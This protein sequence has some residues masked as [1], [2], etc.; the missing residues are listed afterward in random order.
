MEAYRSIFKK[1]WAPLTAG[2]L[3]GFI[4]TLMFAFDS[5]W[6]VF[7]GLRNWGLHIL[8]FLGAGDVAQRS[9]LEY[10]T[11][12]MDIA[13]ITGAF[14]AAL[15]AN[16]FGVRIPPLREAIK[17][18]IGGVLMGIG[19]NFARGCT[20]GG[21][22]SSIAAMSVSGLCMMLGLFIGVII[23]LKYLLWENR[24]AA[25]TGFKAGRSFG[26]PS[27]IQIPLG[28]L[29]L[30]AGLVGVPYYYDYLDYNELGV[31]FAFSAALGVISQRSRFCI[32][33][34][35]RDPFMTGDGEMTK[36]LIIAFVVAIAGFA[37]I[38][39]AEIR[40]A[41][42]FINPSAGW[43]AI[44][45]GVIFGVGMT[46]AGGCASGSLWRAGEGQVKLMLALLGFALSA[47][48][49][50]LIL[51]LVFNY[52]YIKRIFLPDVFDSWLVALGILFG[53]MLLWYLVVSWNE[54]TEKLVILK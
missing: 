28:L 7:T 32:V 15:M 31:I 12:V 37:V 50:H 29:V 40:E 51:N 16:Q 38:K 17:G 26:V 43:P 21:F 9:P 1:Q 39:F 53:I 41:T 11:S 14:G 5:P 49:G 34:S 44:Y 22:Y 20:I 4:N 35:I 10:T 23:G 27:F 54:R 13:F 3:I 42:V 48:G 2:I 46:I 25:G 8:E 36:G 52:S 6:A 24:R 19:A 33:R 18:F 30:V 45:G 47:A